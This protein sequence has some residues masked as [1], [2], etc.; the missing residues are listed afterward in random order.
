MEKVG[1]ARAAAGGGRHDIEQSPV[2]SSG[3]NG[4]AERAIQ[5]LEQQARVVKGALEARWRDR[6]PARR[7]G[8][9]WFGDGE[10]WAH[11][12]R[13]SKRPAGK[14]SRH[15][16]RRGGVLEAQSSRRRPQEVLFVQCNPEWES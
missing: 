7:A 1:R 10:R 4:I 3:K 16:A 2:G 14:D 6:V 8:V 15:R 13:T 12:G 5:S 9:P 11:G